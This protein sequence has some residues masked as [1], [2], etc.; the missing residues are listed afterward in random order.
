MNKENIGSFI[1]EKRI[2]QKLS[3][4]DLADKAGVGY[5]RILEMEKDRKNY[6]IEVLISVINVLGYDLLFDRR[7]KSPC[8]VDLKPITKS[9]DYGIDVK[10]WGSI[11][12]DDPWH[13]AKG[14]STSIFNFKNVIPAKEGDENSKNF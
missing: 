5:R 8:I 4:Y 7:D 6:S 1:R 12:G 10:A 9:K 3:Q 14:Y 11:A 13:S 2:E